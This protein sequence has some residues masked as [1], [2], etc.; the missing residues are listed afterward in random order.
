MTKVY[1]I[2]PTCRGQNV[3]FQAGC[4]TCLDCGWSSCAIAW[5]VEKIQWIQKE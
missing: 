1:D 2:C 3:I 4:N 5:L